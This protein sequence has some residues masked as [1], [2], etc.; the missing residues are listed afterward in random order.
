MQ[1]LISK[2]L[3]VLVTV[4][5]LCFLGFA[6]ATTLG[7]PNWSAEMLELQGN[8]KTFELQGGAEF[9][10]FEFSVTP[11]PPYRWTVVRGRDRQS[12]SNNAI[13]PKAIVDSLKAVTQEQQTRIRELQERRGD[14]QK[15]LD[16]WKGNSTADEQALGDRV[17]DL[18]KTYEATRAEASQLATQVARG[19]EEAQKIEQRIAERREDVI[20]LR[21]QLAEIRTDGFRQRE[22]RQELTDQLQE[23]LAILEQAKERNQQLHQSQGGAGVAVTGSGTL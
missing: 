8:A 12:V 15:L 3:V 18:L 9:R 17:A 13:A 2:C 20:R 14:L 19:T 22:L 5:S 6:L 4:C 7:G 23:L 10:G 16:E 11:S 1:T 21:T